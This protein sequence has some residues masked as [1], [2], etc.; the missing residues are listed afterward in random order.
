[1]S[2]I[3]FSFGIKTKIKTWI[4]KTLNKLG[5]QDLL[6]VLLPEKT[7]KWRK[8]KP[9]GEAKNTFDDAILLIKGRIRLSLG[10]RRSE[11]SFCFRS[12]NFSTIL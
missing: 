1:M 7:E 10:V 11:D 2:N 3:V 4:K 9:T 8:N 6:K 5:R 12:S